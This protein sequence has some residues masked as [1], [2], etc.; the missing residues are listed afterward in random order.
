MLF[1]KRRF[2]R[3]FNRAL[4]MMALASLMPASDAAAAEAEAQRDPPARMLFFGD[5]LTAGYGLAPEVAYPARIQEKIDARNLPVEVAVGAVSGDTSAGG[6]RRIDWMLRRPV[7]VFVLAL[8]ANDGLRGIDPAATEANLQAILDKVRV[9]YPE[10]KLVV[11]GMRMPP[12][13]GK[14]YTEAFAAI[15]PRLA[16]AN[17]V[18][19]IPFLLKGVGGQLDLNLPDR[20]HPNAAGHALLADT[21]WQYLEPLLRP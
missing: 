6:L 8:G 20:I 19:L 11:A 3:F 18:T 2:F 21:V 16:E 13:L 10:A 9:R 14:E 7:D 17:D 12:S 5:S 1:Y 15:Y 4:Q